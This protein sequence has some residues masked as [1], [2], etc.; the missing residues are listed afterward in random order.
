MLT[1]PAPAVLQALKNL[2]TIQEWSEVTKFLEQELTALQLHL[3]EAVDET[4]RRQFQGRAKCLKE[5]LALVRTA[6]A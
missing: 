2:R 5:F 4:T 3:I 1:R 6:S